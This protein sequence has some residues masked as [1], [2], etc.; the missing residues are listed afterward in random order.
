MKKKA[1]TIGHNGNVAAK[2]RINPLF[3]DGLSISGRIGDGLP[4]G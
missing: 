1:Q 4:I 3:G 2:P